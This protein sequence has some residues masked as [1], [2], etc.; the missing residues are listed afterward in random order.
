MTISRRSL[1]QGLTLGA[2]SALLLPML[3]QLELQA[4]GVQKFPL[5][6]VF[7][8]QNNGFHPWAAQ[9][10]GIELTDPGPDKVVD[11]PL[12]GHKLPADL[13]PLEA[14][15]RRVT[16]LQHLSAVHTVP[17]H[18]A[19]FSA[20]SGARRLRMWD[21]TAR[22]PTI[23]AVVARRSPGLLPILNI[24]IQSDPEGEIA[25]DGNGLARVCSA[26]GP[27]KPI[28]TQTRPAS[29]YRALFGDL[30][31]K[32]IEQQSNILDQA[33]DEI[34]RLKLY[35]PPP[36]LEHFEHYLDAFET[37]DFKQLGLQTLAQGERGTLARKPSDDEIGHVEASRLGAMFELAGAALVSGLTNVVTLCSGLCDP[38]GT[39]E[40]LGFDIPVHELGHFEDVDGRPW[41]DVYTLM[42][43]EHLGHVARLVERL[44]S[45]P[46]GDGTMMDNTLILYTSDAAETHHSKGL[47]WPFVL[48]GNA[49]GKLRSG[50]FI[51]YPGVGKPGNRLINALYCTLAQAAGSSATEFNLDDE[52][53]AKDSGGPLVELLA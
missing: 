5:R 52:L 38:N 47:Q 8:L 43:K 34:K 23:D 27:N 24:G 29:V 25:P 17:F 22:A 45:V 31:K 41:K 19:F 35:L 30:A 26:W 33:A 39:Y 40:G 13:S 50:R 18:S 28:A 48:I 37:F 53:R 32:S 42:R 16:I 11:L 6:F 46:E 3:R 2:G 49:A 44:E 15:K 10:E 20:L 12:E 7:V 14:H 1:L 21:D 4:N 51:D 36:E 9:P